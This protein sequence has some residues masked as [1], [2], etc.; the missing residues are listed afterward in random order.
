MSTAL[1][2]II[3][4]AGLSGLYAATK[5]KEAGL[6]VL[7]L[8]ARDRVG[9]RTHSI[10]VGNE[11]WDMGAGWIGHNQPILS[12]L[13]QKF[14]IQT[15]D[16]FDSGNHILIINGKKSTYFGNISTLNRKDLGELDDV[17]KKWDQLMLQ[18]PLD[19]PYEAAKA[20]EW[21]SMN[22][23]MWEREN[24]RSET[25]INLLNFIIRTVFAVEP[26]QLSFLFFLFFLRAGGGY[27]VLSDIHGGAQQARTV[28]GNQQFSECLARGLGAP[29]VLLNAPVRKI[30]Q[31][32]G[33]VVVHSDLGIYRAKYA[34]VSVPPALSGAIE[35]NPPL[36]AAREQLHQRMPMGCVI[37]CYVI[38]ERAFWREAGYS[39]EVLT[40]DSPACL[41]YDAVTSK[42]TPALV[43]FVAA[44]AATHWSGKEEE[45]KE[46]LVKQL[47]GMFGEVAAK[48]KQILIKDWQLEPWSKG[49]YVGVMP[50]G[51]LSAYGKALR[52]PVGRVHWAGTETATAWIGYME[53]AL[54]SGERAA[55]EIIQK[56]SSAC[57][58]CSSDKVAARL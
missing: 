23:E 41:F 43:A 8:E 49:C 20:L 24:M 12:G 58:S 11:R 17:V 6:S 9:G 35:F 48:P 40:T 16:Q 44:A 22:L 46:A 56:I 47:V 3:I 1:D 13:A 57:S 5:L 15:I 4:G 26:S 51:M 18:V 32:E 28:G 50:S 25:A 19:K 45:L 36:P 34:I 39:G 54:Q 21:D 37:K 2:C 53:G 14:G 31:W 30:V 38:Y 27:N 55:D 29:N 33:G 7:V 10:Q 42:G 52:E